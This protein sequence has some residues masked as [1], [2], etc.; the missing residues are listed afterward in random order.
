MFAR[1]Y[2]RPGNFPGD[3]IGPIDCLTREQA[4]I[5]LIKSPCSGFYANENRPF[6]HSRGTYILEGK[7]MTVTRQ[8]KAIQP[9]SQVLSPKDG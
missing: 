3:R 9:R 7:E 6:I 1:A 4:V 2:K 5:W 8:K